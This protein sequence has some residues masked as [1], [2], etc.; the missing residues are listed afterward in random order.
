MAKNNQNNE[1]MALQEQLQSKK[2]VGVMIIIGLFLCGFVSGAEWWNPFSWFGEEKPLPTEA[3]KEMK[4]DGITIEKF[5]INNEQITKL[6]DEKATYEI[7]NIFKTNENGDVKHEI[8]LT[9]KD[10]KD[11]LYN[12][13]ALIKI[14][15]PEVRWNGTRYVLDSKPV[16][17]GSYY[18]D[19]KLIVPNIFMDDKFNKRISYRDIAEKGGYVLAYESLGEYYLELRIDN[20]NLKAGEEYYIDPS[21]TNGTGGFSTIGLG[22]DVPSGVSVYGDYIY[23]ADNNDNFVY[24]SD[25]SG[26]NQTGGFSSL[27]LGGNI[28]GLQGVKFNGTNF[29][30]AESEEDFIYFTN[31]AGVNISIGFPVPSGNP[32]DI[33][34]NGSDIYTCNDTNK[35]VA[36]YNKNGVLLR[37]INFTTIG[38]GRPLGITMYGNNIW[39]ADFTDEFLY[40]TD[41][42]LN[43]ISNGINLGTDIG[44]GGAYRLDTADGVNFYL[45]DDVDDFVYHIWGGVTITLNTPSDGSTS[46]SQDVIFNCSGTSGVNLKNISLFIDG[47]KNYTVEGDAT[48]LEL[49]TTLKLSFGNHIW[50]CNATDVDNSNTQ[51]ENRS[52]SLGYSI[53]AIT[54]NNNTLNGASEL[55]TLNVS[56]NNSIYTSILASLVYNNTKYTAGGTG[57]GYTYSFKRTINV[58]SV[59]ARTNVTFYWEN[60]LYNGV[61]WDIYNSSF[62]NQTINTVGVDNCSSYDLVIYNYTILDEETKEKVSNTTM[63]IQVNL[64]DI[65]RTNLVSNYSYT[66]KEVNPIKICFNGTV[67]PT[68]N[69]SLDSTVKYWA[70]DTTKNISYAIEAYNVLNSTLSNSSYFHDIKLYGL[71]NEDSTAFQLTFRD[72]SYSLKGNVLVYLYRQYIGDNDFKVVEVPIT[73]TN[74]QTIL[75]L[76]RNDEIYNIVFVDVGGKIVAAF[77]KITAFCQD[78]TIGSCE[79]FLNAPLEEEEIYDYD[80]EFGITYTGPDYSNATKTVTFSY[81]VTNLSEKKVRM[82]VIKDSGFNN[83]SICT[84]EITSAA[85]TLS[86]DVTDWSTNSRYLFIKIYVDE[87]LFIVMQKDLESSQFTFGN[88]AGAFY[89]FLLIILLI[90]IF[91]YD[92]QALILSLGIGWVV[93]IGLGLISGKIIGSLTGGIWFII[94]II[95]FAWKLNKEERGT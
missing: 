60:R 46:L 71:N 10:S 80:D 75:H 69:Y 11:V 61:S 82:E 36:N 88:A 48:T 6:Q 76:V 47:I 7:N 9:N 15:Y 94:C 18:K 95:I 2:T 34:F 14:D 92:K 4:V 90:S 57:S 91:S 49:N 25:K 24:K 54:Y 1:K 86:C 5:S 28:D 51:S 55:F 85:G 16:K 70:N 62:Y 30:I 81:V 29:L 59:S 56:Y 42:A 63:E 37:A 22:S 41:L 52:M 65:T 19:G 32:V 17:F 44:A 21:Y 89:A 84:D 50:S 93:V 12:Y 33:A 73:D 79:I 77:N 26:N 78:Y 87:E 58:P 20:L 35:M 31:S 68:I 66:F 83:R 53:D 74:G 64:Y 23:V 3:L 72:S 13:S 43:N 8:Y 27:D 39:I 45:T 40:H 67:L 38:A